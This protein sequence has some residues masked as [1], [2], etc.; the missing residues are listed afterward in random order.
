LVEEVYEGSLADFWSIWV[1]SAELLQ[2]AIAELLE[3]VGL[4]FESE[5]ILT[6][7]DFSRLEGFGRSQ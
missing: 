2:S 3:G 6:I 7:V 5:G 4:R 1:E